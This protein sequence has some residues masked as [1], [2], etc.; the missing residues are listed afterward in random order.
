VGAG[1]Q[2]GGRTGS[3][4][5]RRSG[6]SGGRARV[7]VRVW[8]VRGVRAWVRVFLYFKP[9]CRVPDAEHSTKKVFCRVPQI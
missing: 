4:R 7:C 9:L 3:R 5:R 6:D 1:S 8:C 2:R